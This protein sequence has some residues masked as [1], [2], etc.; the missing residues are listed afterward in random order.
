MNGTNG[1]E[2]DPLTAPIEEV[3]A[4]SAE[5]SI[6]QV[7]AEVATPGPLVAP[8]TPPEFRP[9][10]VA[11]G[12][13]GPAPVPPLEEA[14]EA[15]GDPQPVQVGTRCECGR[16][17]AINPATGEVEEVTGCVETTRNPN[18]R[19]APGHDAR[20]KGLL[21]RAGERGHRVREIGTDANK[22]PTTVAARI[23]SAMARR[24]DEGIKR[25]KR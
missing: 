9:Q 10:V 13:G 7:V 4:A 8:A 6:E 24:V 16:W 20:F 11:Y 25:R 21:I 18:S 1:N 23:S 22:L 15:D 14:R 12:G 2:I 3:M 5:K 19:F 17:E